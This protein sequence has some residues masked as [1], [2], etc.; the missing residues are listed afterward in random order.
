LTRSWLDDHPGPRSRSGWWGDVR[1]HVKG[2]SEAGRAAIVSA[3][4]ASSVRAETVRTGSRGRRTRRSTSAYELSG[5][6]DGA[7]A[8]GRATVAVPPPRLRRHLT[9]GDGC[10]RCRRAH[11]DRLGPGGRPAAG[12]RTR[13]SRRHAV[14]HLPPRSA[15]WKHIIGSAQILAL[16]ARHQPGRG[17]DGTG[18]FRGLSAADAER[19]SFLLSTPVMS[20]ARRL[21][22]GSRGTC[23]A[24]SATGSRAGARGQA[25]CPASGHLRVGAVPGQVTFRTRT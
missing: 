11:E 19:L 21:P 15:M 24:P 7:Q 9:A 13:Q 22:Q 2:G 17:R 1:A 18:M 16:L 12:G 8:G 20:F 5:Q 10:R 25:S 14:P 23:S 4:T 3:S 6:R